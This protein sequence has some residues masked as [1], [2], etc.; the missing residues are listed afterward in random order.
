M[1]DS[2]SLP[3]E[4]TLLLERWNGGDR[5]AFEQ[6][7]ALAYGDLHRIAQSY[8]RHSGAG[9]T[10]QATGLVHELYIKLTRVRNA[11]LKD[12]SH[13]YAFAARLMRMILI[14]YARRTHSQRR[15][16]SAIRVPLHEE[17]AWVD[18]AGEDL[19]A[20]NELLEELET[21][22]ARKVRV[23]ELRYF[24][25]CTNEEAADLLNVSRPTIDRDLEFAKAWL[26]RRL[27][28]DNP[29]NRRKPNANANARTPQPASSNEPGSGTVA[30]RNTPDAEE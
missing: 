23:I 14:D 7:L 20:L 8:L 26:Y 3:H 16:G 30:E 27:S 19:L 28:S 22:D 17:M 18:A 15:P 5:E 25:G 12:R 13:F 11:S 24:L 21:L 2:P 4:I 6:V 1:P 29:V 10:L 9:Q